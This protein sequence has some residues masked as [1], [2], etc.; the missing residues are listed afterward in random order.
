MKFIHEEVSVFHW[1]YTFYCW[2]WQMDCLTSDNT[3]L[4]FTLSPSEKIEKHFS[5][6][7]LYKSS[8]FPEKPYRNNHSL[9]SYRRLHGAA[10]RREVLTEKSSPPGIKSDGWWL[11]L[12]QAGFSPSME[13]GLSQPSLQSWRFRICMAFPQALRWK[14]KEIMAFIKAVIERQSFVR[15]DRS[16][17]LS[18]GRQGSPSLPQQTSQSSGFTVKRCVLGCFLPRPGLRRALIIPFC[19]L[20]V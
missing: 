6:L 1:R 20:S 9:A 13:R 15:K 2:A 8:W 17:W 18:N 5:D 14:W 16:L 3:C 19:Q 7:C 4:C 12:L 11:R 10:W